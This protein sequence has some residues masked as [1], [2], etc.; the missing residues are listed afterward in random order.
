[1]EFPPKEHFARGT[2]IH[3]EFAGNL[4][5]ANLSAFPAGNTKILTAVAQARISSF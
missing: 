3:N 4:M 1:M 5:S 2:G